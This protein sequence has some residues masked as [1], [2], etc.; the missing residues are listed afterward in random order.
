M[1]VLFSEEEWFH[2]SGYVNAHGKRYWLVCRKSHFNPS[3]HGVNTDVWCS[4][5]AN[6]IIMPITVTHQYVTHN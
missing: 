1:L 4:V 6:R 5:S 2:L 3:L